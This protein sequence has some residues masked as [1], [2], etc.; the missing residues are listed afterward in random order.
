[1][2]DRRIWHEHDI[3]EA[4]AA[5][6]TVVTA[7]ERLARAVRLAHAEAR[8]GGGEQVW[9]RAEVLSWNGLLHMLFTRHEDAAL[10]GGPR[11][12]ALRLLDTHQTEALW[13]SVLRDSPAAAALLQPGVTAQATQQA[14]ALCQAYDLSLERISQH[15]D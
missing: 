2:A 5:G 8:H 4:L 1:M 9:E 13:E 6:A 14:W 11:G 7:S 15:A 3:L 10:D 12:Q